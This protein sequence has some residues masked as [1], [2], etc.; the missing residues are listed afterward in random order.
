M[1]A[2]KEKRNA[3][4]STLKWATGCSRRRRILTRV[5]YISMYSFYDI[6]VR[7]V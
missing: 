1:A 5:Y 4:E 2:E 7:H 3:I 6:W